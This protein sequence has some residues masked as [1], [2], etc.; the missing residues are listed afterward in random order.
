MVKWIVKMLKEHWLIMEVAEE[1]VDVVQPII[2]STYREDAL[3]SKIVNVLEE[4]IFSK[5]NSIV[6]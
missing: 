3:I 4:L 2:E 5:E 6:D 1:L